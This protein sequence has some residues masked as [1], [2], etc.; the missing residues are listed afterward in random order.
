MKTKR[1]R[2]ISR[3]LEETKNKRTKSETDDKGKFSNVKKVQPAPSEASDS[4]ET[5][6]AVNKVSKDDDKVSADEKVQ[7]EKAKSEEGEE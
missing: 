6:N 2:D 4:I 1:S 3:D 5:S 7:Q